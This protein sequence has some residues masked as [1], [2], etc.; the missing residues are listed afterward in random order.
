MTRRKKC[1]SGIK[2]NI[3]QWNNVKNVNLKNVPA[4]INKLGG[5]DGLINNKII[6]DATLWGENKYNVNH[7][8]SLLIKYANN[9]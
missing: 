2:I 9:L 7:I 1:P 4:L 3:T 6:S 8:R 5:L